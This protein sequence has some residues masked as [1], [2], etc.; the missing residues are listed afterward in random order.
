[1]ALYADSDDLYGKLGVRRDKL[2]LP[3]KCNVHADIV[4]LYMPQLVALAHTGDVRAM[5]ELGAFYKYG[6]YLPK[7]DIQCNAWWLKAAEQG[8]CDAQRSL[9]VRLERGTGEGGSATERRADAFR[10][11]LRSAVQG[12]HE[13]FR[14]AFPLPAMPP[15]SPNVSRQPRPLLDR[16]RQR[17][18]LSLSLSLSVCVCVCVSLP[19][20]LPAASSRVC[21]WPGCGMSERSRATCPTSLNACTPFWAWSM[22]PTCSLSFLSSPRAPKQTV[23]KKWRAS[24]RFGHADIS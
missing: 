21:G 11:Y 17:L 10:W 2:Y 7:D 12:H 22:T 4:A 9:A 16:C 15:A 20:T 8:R 1:M 24:S 14:P 3:T 19:A 13:G 18:S 23:G 5:V 6:V